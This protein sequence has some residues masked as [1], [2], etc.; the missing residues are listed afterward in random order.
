MGNTNRINDSYAHAAGDHVL[1]NVA[2]LLQGVLREYD[3]VARWG[4]EEFLLLLPNTDII[5]AMKVAERLREIVACSH[6][7]FEEQTIP[8]TMTLGVAVLGDENWHSTLARADEALYRGKRQGRNCV[9][10]ASAP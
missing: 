1:V 8:V 10:Q 2:N 6:L 3:V 4:R 5:E 7:S 9:V